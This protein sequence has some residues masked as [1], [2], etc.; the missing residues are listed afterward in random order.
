MLAYGNRAAGRGGR[1][2]PLYPLLRAYYEMHP[3]VETSGRLGA[4]A[5]AN[6]LEELG[7]SDA[8]L[9]RVRAQL[10]TS[11]VAVGGADFRAFFGVV[12]RTLKEHI[13][14]EVFLDL[15]M[16]PNPNNGMSVTRP[17]SCTAE[18]DRL[19]DTDARA[20]TS[21]G[22]SEAA[23]QGTGRRQHAGGEAHDTEAGESGRGSDTAGARTH[24]LVSPL[25]FSSTAAG[26]VAFS[27]FPA[28]CAGSGSR[29]LGG[30][31]SVANTKRTCA[32]DTNLE[33]LEKR[34]DAAGRRPM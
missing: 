15:D 7:V 20:A 10:Q 8:D 21:A 9:E 25:A 12:Q 18:L 4:D 24:Q 6:A 3:D 30:D 11:G 1:A 5:V 16:S 33:A 13:G 23:V 2:G 27:S 29:P 32:S 28:S 19:V 14:T 31:G 34:L 26:T 17:R 22:G